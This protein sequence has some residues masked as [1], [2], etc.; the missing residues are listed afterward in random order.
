MNMLLMHR[1]NKL[2]LNPES[3]QGML[4][5]LEKEAKLFG[6]QQKQLDQA[7]NFAKLVALGATPSGRKIEKRL[8]PEA[9]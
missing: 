8:S 6:I 5:L 7:Y 4:T 2:E 9:L 3:Q 1:A